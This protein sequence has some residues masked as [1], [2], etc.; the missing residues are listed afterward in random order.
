MND[1]LNWKQRWKILAS[2][3]SYP[4]LVICSKVQALSIVI[5]V[6]CRMKPLVFVGRH[7][8]Y[9]AFTQR[10][11]GKSGFLHILSTLLGIS[12]VSTMCLQSCIQF[13]I[14]VPLGKMWVR[15]LDQFYFFNELVSQTVQ[16]WDLNS[17]SISAKFSWNQALTFEQSTFVWKWWNQLGMLSFKW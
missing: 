10:S 2:L 14:T 1:F 8:F 7:V 6:W 11:S 17:C 15:S 5:Y 13:L 12:H 4:S 9:F 3:L 16:Q